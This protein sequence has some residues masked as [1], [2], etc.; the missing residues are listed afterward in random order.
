MSIAR[1]RD[2]PLPPAEFMTLVCGEAE[3][4]EQTFLAVGKL[5]VEMLEKD[6]MLRPGVAFLDVGCGCGRLA[7]F[8]CDSPIASYVG[9]DRH[10][11][12][13]DWCR[14]ELTSR[15]SRLRFECFNLKS[16]YDDLDGEVGQ[17]D[18][19]TFRFPFAD[20][21]SD[22]TMLASVFTHMPL[23]EVSNYLL[24][25]RRVTRPGGKVLFS[26]FLTEENTLRP[27]VDFLFDRTQLMDHIGR[28]GFSCEQ[29]EDTGRHSWLLLTAPA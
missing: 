16:A 5:L 1:V 28:A 21:S 17:I 8:L 14:R 4:I 15:D 25:L 3:N 19:A 20:R 7:R 27:G 11:G 26:T 6:D 9:F 13:I 10:S 22:S 2:L 18:A 29:R 23:V 24:E 12:M